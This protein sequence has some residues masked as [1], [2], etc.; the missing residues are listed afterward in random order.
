MPHLPSETFDANARAALSDATLRGA[1]GRA[2]DLFGAKRREA[3]ATLPNWEAL[4]E[5]ARAIKAHALAR[6]DE[7]LLEFERNAR[8]A[9]TVVHWARDGREACAIVLE[10][11]RRLGEAPGIVKAKSMTTEE[12]HLN[13][14]LEA[15]G[16]APVETDLGEWI[17][18]LAGEV[19]SHILAPAIHKTK[20]QIAE[21]FVDELAVELTEDERELT[22]IARRFLRER[23]ADAALGVSGAN[24]LVA[25][26]G[27]VAIVENEGNIRLSTSLPRVHVALVGIEKVLPRFEDLELFL[28]L[29]PRSGSGQQL[30]CYAS[31]LSGPKRAGGEGPDELHVVLLDNGRSAMLARELTR[32]SLA[33]IRCGACL[34][35]CPVYQQVGGHAYGSV[36]P[37]PIGAVITP[38][39]GGLAKTAQ[40]PFASSLCGACRDVCPVKIDLPALLLDLRAAVVEERELPGTQGRARADRFER[41]AFR[42]WAWI[43]ANPRRFE[44]AAGAAR[45]AQALGLLERGPMARFVE[46]WTRERALRPLA[47]KS[48]RE[49]WREGLE[50]EDAP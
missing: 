16:L 3:V 50:R 29:L 25:E 5:R 33:C 32:Q 12:V 4:R 10:L 19:P 6:L 24:F 15:E 38:Q 23:F 48:F 18:Q 28:R 43:A 27:S 26:T 40:L 42:V 49:L 35:V 8:A 7:Q 46:P 45:R 41:F 20:R 31:I 9:G 34:N 22:A 2:T 37:G 21:L 17:V 13:E 39:L 44:F 14:A 11:A 36:Y 1:L 47:A 30:T